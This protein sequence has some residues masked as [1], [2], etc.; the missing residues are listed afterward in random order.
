M[1]SSTKTLSIIDDKIDCSP[2]LQLECNEWG[3]NIKGMSREAALAYLNLETTAAK[4]DGLD[5]EYVGNLP[6]MF[7]RRMSPDETG[8]CMCARLLMMLFD[9]SYEE[10][11]KEKF[12]MVKAYIDRVSPIVDPEEMGDIY[13][14]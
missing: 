3:L 8:S 14:N 7:D 11:S 4:S 1:V 5:C 9:V 10:V 12:Q 6:L 13:D 2:E